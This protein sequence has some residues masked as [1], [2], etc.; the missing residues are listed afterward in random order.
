[1]IIGVTKKAQ[2]LFSALPTIKDKEDGKRFA[3]AN[4]LFSWH[5]NYINVN[6]KKILILLN[7]LTYTPIVLQDVNAQKKKQLSQLIP[8]AIRVAFEI[9]GIPNKKTEEYLTLAGDIQV[10]TTSNRSIM[11]SINLVAEELSEFDLNLTQTINREEMTFYSNYL[12]TKLFKQG[13]GSS[14]KALQE[15]LNKP[16]KLEVVVEATPYAIEKTWDYSEIS[17]LD[18]L[19]VSE[20]QWDKNRE[21]LVENNEKLLGALKEYMISEKGISEKT[22]KRHIENLD[23][24]LNVYLA[25]YAQVSPVNSGD[26]VWNFLGDFFVR[27]N[28]S[29]SHTSL[30]QNGSALKKMYQFLYEADEISKIDLTNI[31]EFIRLGIQEGDEYLSSIMNDD[32]FWFWE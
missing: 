7:D 11:G 17:Q 14:T 5:A 1:M 13:Y 10:T 6:R 26:S 3:Q 20:Q 15:V 25:D 29:S 4:P 31:H 21:W 22:A 32:D 27:K 2:P 12:H 18:P 23:F 9:A 24:Y 8:D 16:L 30:K 19:T 28:L